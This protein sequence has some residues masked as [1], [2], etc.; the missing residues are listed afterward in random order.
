[1]NTDWSEDG[2]WAMSDNL[3]LYFSSN[4][5]ATRGGYDIWIAVRP[6]PNSLD[7]S[8]SH[9]DGR[10]NS[11]DPE[12]SPTLSPDG[13]V[14]FYYSSGD[15]YRASRDFSGLPFSAGVYVDIVN[16]PRVN[17]GDPFFAPR[18]R[19][20]YFTS[21][22]RG[23][24]DIFVS[25]LDSAPTALD[26]VNTDTSDEETPVLSADELTMYYSRIASPDEYNS[27]IWIA[28]RAS[29]SDPFESTI[30]EELKSNG[31]DYP[32]SLS[33]DVCTLYFVSTRNGNRDFFFATRR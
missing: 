3:T 10:I 15:I 32:E 16:D 33:P 5:P 25:T 24:Y 30:V 21:R 20:L 28:K 29:L 27:Q 23:T 4:R 1:L 18:T 12:Q 19:L 11:G 13:T 2:I 31:V 7:W 17:E 8:V 6:E 9:L 26:S 14:M 22:R